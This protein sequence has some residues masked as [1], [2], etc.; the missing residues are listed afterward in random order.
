MFWEPGPAIASRGAILHRRHR[1][2]AFLGELYLIPCSLE[3]LARASKRQQGAAC[4]AG[5]INHYLKRQ[6]VIAHLVPGPQNRGLKKEAKQ[7]ARLQQNLLV[8]CPQA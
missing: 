1:N 2:A 6:H 7:F 3:P 4:C 8:G 5:S